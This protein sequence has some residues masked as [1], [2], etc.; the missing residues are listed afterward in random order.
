MRR[1]RPALL[2]IRQAQP[3]GRRSGQDTPAAG[4]ERS[5]SSGSTGPNAKESSLGPVRESEPAP[6]DCY[7]LNP[8]QLSRCAPAQMPRSDVQGSCTFPCCSPRRPET[9]TFWSQGPLLAVCPPVLGS[10]HLKDSLRGTRRPPVRSSRLPRFCFALRFSFPSVE[11]F[12][13]RRKGAP[14]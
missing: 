11:P 10:R 7:S 8:S 5:R 4:G 14:L 12:A 3:A 13:G 6:K 1:Q 9:A 2:S